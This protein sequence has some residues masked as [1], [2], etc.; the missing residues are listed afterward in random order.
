MSTA[1][2]DEL[3]QLENEIAMLE[4]FKDNAA[5]VDAFF[6]TRRDNIVLEAELAQVQQNLDFMTSLKSK[7]DDKVRKEN[8]RLAM[9]KRVRAEA[10]FKDLLEELKKPKVQD[11]ILKKCI[12]DL[13]K[14]SVP[15]AQPSL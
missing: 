6:D 14:M 5:V 3:V 8:E 15:S 7:L 12:A 1:A 13:G 11:A 2:K 9:E 10:L 4:E